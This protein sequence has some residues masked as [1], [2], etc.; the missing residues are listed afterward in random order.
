M[1]VLIIK[2]ISYNY[3]VELLNSIAFYFKKFTIFNQ[4]ELVITLFGFY[5]FIW[6]WMIEYISRLHYFIWEKSTSF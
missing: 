3:V 2:F 5:W 4:Y 6:S 1:F